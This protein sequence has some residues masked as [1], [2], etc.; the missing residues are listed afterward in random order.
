MPSSTCTGPPEHHRHT[1][2]GSELAHP[3]Y[4]GTVSDARRGEGTPLPPRGSATPP[5]PQTRN[6]TTR[7]RNTMGS[8][9]I[10]W[11][12]AARIA[13]AADATTDDFR[14]VII[15]NT[16]VLAVDDAQIA[17]AVDKAA[18][19]DLGLDLGPSAVVKVEGKPV[20]V[21]KGAPTAFAA[22]PAPNTGPAPPRG[23]APRPAHG[24][25]PPPGE[26]HRPHPTPPGEP[27]PSRSP[28][29]VTGPRRPAPPQPARSI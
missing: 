3:H 24:K 1:S 29:G 20:Q 22:C 10:D 7:K 18:Y 2:C 21:W 13:Q 17:E 8:T 14:S 19:N 27:Q 23:G 9:V 12:L 4:C 28:A 15:G 6:T 25:E 16:Q 26:Q 11:T 5:T